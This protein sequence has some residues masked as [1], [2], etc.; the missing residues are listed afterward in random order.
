PVTQTWHLTGSGKFTETV[1][2]LDDKGHMS[3]QDVERECEVDIALRWGGGYDTNVRTFVNI[4]ATPKG[5]SHLAGFEA[6]LLK[7]LRKQVEVNARRLKVSTKDAAERIE[8]D[9]V[10]A[11]LTAVVTV[12]LAE[13]QFEG[14]TKE[15]LGTAPVRGIVARVVEKELNALLTSTKRDDK[16]QAALL[17]DKVVAEMRAR[18]TARKQKEI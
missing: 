12:R 11:G 3:P 9:D 14:Q 6:G 16:T 1:P 7:L 18:I 17:L 15:V 8:K 4:I 2:V 13:P 10:L 5:G